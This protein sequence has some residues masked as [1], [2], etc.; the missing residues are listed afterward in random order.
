MSANEHCDVTALF[1]V[2][3]ETNIKISR[4]LGPLSHI[5]ISANGVISVSLKS[6]Q[7]LY[8]ISSHHNCFVPYEAGLIGKSNIEPQIILQTAWS[9]G[10][11]LLS[12]CQHTSAVASDIRLRYIHSCNNPPAVYLGSRTDYIKLI[13]SVQYTW[14]KD[15]LCNGTDSLPVSGVLHYSKVLTSVVFLLKFLLS[16]SLHEFHETCHSVTSNFMKED[17]ERC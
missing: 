15:V 17:S 3:L 7:P 4:D 10:N 1:C 2:F 11:P 14:Q 13:V 12:D 6:P 5:S 16:F 8:P 9:D